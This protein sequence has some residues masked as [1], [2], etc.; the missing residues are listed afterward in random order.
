MKPFDLDAFKAGA[1][2]VTRD[3]RD[4]RYLGEIKNDYPMIVAAKRKD[5]TENIVQ[6]KISGKYSNDLH[7]S[8]DLI[9]MKPVKRT[10]HF[11]SWKFKGKGSVVARATSNMYDE[12]EY[13]TCL[14]DGSLSDFT[15]HTIEIEE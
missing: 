15:Y 8:Y 14:D 10:L 1:I 7:I 11:A 2:A 5:G 13:A 12:K 3:G 4:A 6:T 9:G